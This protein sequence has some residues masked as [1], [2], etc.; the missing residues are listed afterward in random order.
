MK[1]HHFSKNHKIIST[2]FMVKSQSAFL[3]YK[4]GQML[5]HQNSLLLRAS[6][7]S[8]SVQY[9]KFESNKSSQ[10]SIMISFK[11]DNKL[12]HKLN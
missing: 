7:L 10:I 2:S 11:S 12:E 9:I 3:P 8:F 1:V 4:S 6:F 5:S